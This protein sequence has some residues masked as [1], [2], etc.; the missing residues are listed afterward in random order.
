[1]RARLVAEPTNLPPAALSISNRLR[2][3]PPH[4]MRCAPQPRTKLDIPRSGLPD[5][6]RLDRVGAS[7]GC[8]ATLRQV[9]VQADLDANGVLTGDEG[10]PVDMRRQDAQSAPHFMCR[11][12]GG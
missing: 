12:L 2:G 10:C 6:L 3:Y 9:L 7:G 1:M 8:R 4:K 5:A 11:R